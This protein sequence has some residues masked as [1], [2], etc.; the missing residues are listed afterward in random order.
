MNIEYD[1]EIPDK[2]KLFSLFISTSWNEKYQLNDTDLYKA[3]INSKFVVSVYID[4]KLIG[5]GRIISDGILHALIVDIIVLP[6]FKRRGIGTIIIN[7]LLNI[8]YRNNIRDIQLFCVKGKKEFY[9]KNGFNERPNIA[10]GME[11]KNRRQFK[12]VGKDN[13]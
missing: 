13:E 10:P 12:P 9:K 5:F 7:K 1:N 8:G 6:E 11:L 3:I 2:D 4:S